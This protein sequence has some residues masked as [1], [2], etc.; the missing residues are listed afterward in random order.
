MLDYWRG[1]IG[2]IEDAIES[3]SKA[4]DLPGA[5]RRLANLLHVARTSAETIEREQNKEGVKP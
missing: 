1:R 3:A 4:E 5:L 2:G